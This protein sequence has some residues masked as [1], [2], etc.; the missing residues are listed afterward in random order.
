[1]L[2]VHWFS[3]A[4]TGHIFMNHPIFGQAWKETTIWMCL[5]KQTHIS[6]YNI[7]VY[8]YTYTM[9]W[10]NY[11]SS[12]NT[13]SHR[14]TERI[15]KTIWFQSNNIYI[16]IYYIYIYMFY[17][18]V[19]FRFVSFKLTHVK[20]ATPRWFLP[21]VVPSPGSFA[22][23]LTWSLSWSKN[24]KEWKFPKRWKWCR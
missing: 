3:V 9:I 21:V 13:K 5:F 15:W 20:V 1:M 23:V 11:N 6:I 24:C 12:P 17:L 22:T 16:Y 18:L 10:A 8:I 7:D 14:E 19:F 4:K 2:E